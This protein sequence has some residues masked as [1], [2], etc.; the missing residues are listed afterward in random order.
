MSEEKVA[1]STDG[2]QVVIVCQGTGC[3]TSDSPRIHEALEKSIAQQG[4]GDTFQV[5]LS[6]CHGFCQ[7]GPIVIAGP[8][9]IF[10]SQVKV[11]A[12][13]QIVESHLKAPGRQS[14]AM[15]TSPSTQSSSA[16]F[17]ET[18]ATSIPS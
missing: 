5:K 13:P 14:P 12:V 11:G 6:G 18:A 2:R 15:V 4:L 9:G 3:V 17:S 16:L 8:E 10:Y 1:V 7:Q